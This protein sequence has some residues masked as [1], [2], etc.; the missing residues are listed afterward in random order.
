MCRPKPW[1]GT[2]STQDV[3]DSYTSPPT[4]L[5]QIH[6]C[7]F[8]APHWPFWKWVYV[9]TKH[10]LTSTM[11]SPYTHSVHWVPNCPP[12]N[13]G[14]QSQCRHIH[15]RGLLWACNLSR[16]IFHHGVAYK[17][18]CPVRD[19]YSNVRA[20]TACISAIFFISKV[21]FY[22]INVITAVSNTKL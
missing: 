3:N 8:A 12:T 4:L 1:I 19:P 17:Y 22:I 9:F 16:L 6:S 21:S 10:L 13:D 7:L 5:F 20:V 11:L 2:L 15:D 14:H 18:F